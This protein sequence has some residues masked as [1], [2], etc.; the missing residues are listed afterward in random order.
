MRTVG[1]YFLLWFRVVLLIWGYSADVS[2]QTVRAYLSAD[3]VKV[4]DRFT[5]TL[6]TEHTRTIDP[7][8]PAASSGENVFGDLEV[9][10]VLRAGT[11]LLPEAVAGMRAD[12]L[13]YEV[14][15][16]ALDTAFVPSLPVYFAAGQDTSFFASS[17]IA[18]PIISMVPPD[19]EDIKDLA[20]L[21][22]FPFNP[23]PWV[24]GLLVVAALAFFLYRYWKRREVPASPVVVQAPKPLV[25]PF[26]A[27]IRRLRKLEKETNLDDALQIKPYFVELTEIMRIYLGR[28]LRIHAMESTSL[29]LM[30]SVNRL[31]NQKR[32]PLEALHLIKRVL[33]VSDLV[34]FAD[35][36]P[37]PEIGHKAL[38]E[39]RK[40]LDVI[41]RALKPPE[42]PPPQ[43]PVTPPTGEA[44]QVAQ[45]A[46]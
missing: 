20:P 44:E 26:E 40:L 10:Q 21:A 5:L 39:V 41:E 2:A 37:S 3:S 43:K 12:S 31:V 32:I 25:S 30:R 46:E 8:F 38:A 7:V 36:H 34:K 11:R 22:E 28:R 9:L 17:P 29:E 15:T 33:H 14:T 19:A 18:L 35:M 27:A 1:T 6:V 4:G 16:F 45:H 42:P 23:W 13:V 24:V